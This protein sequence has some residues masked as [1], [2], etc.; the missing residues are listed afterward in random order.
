MILVRS[1]SLRVRRRGFVSSPVVHIMWGTG[2]IA[3][4]QLAMLDGASS[5]ARL[6]CRMTEKF[7]VFN[8]QRFF[9]E[10]VDLAGLT[11]IFGEEKIVEIQIRVSRYGFWQNDCY[12]V[13]KNS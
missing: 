6:F 3:H 7:Q 1:L 13:L 4:S 10:T 11:R 9:R 5:T 2:R 12:A 8:R